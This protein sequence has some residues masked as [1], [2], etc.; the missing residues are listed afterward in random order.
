MFAIM[1]AWDLTPPR[2]LLLHIVVST[3]DSSVLGL[4]GIVSGTSMWL[5][6]LGTF[7]INLLNTVAP[8]SLLMLLQLASFI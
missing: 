2:V 7:P 4:A 8:I 1:T 5:Q 6:F 3:Q